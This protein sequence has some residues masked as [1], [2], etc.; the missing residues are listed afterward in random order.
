MPSPSFDELLALIREQGEFARAA[1]DSNEPGRRVEAIHAL[2]TIARAGGV[3]ADRAGELRRDAVEQRDVSLGAAAGGIELLARS[4]PLFDAGP[5]A[6]RELG[7]ALPQLADSVGR[8]LRAGLAWAALA[9]AL[10]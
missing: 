7:D 4:R 10:M 6:V 8:E 2:T 5:A 3:P 9:D 1:L